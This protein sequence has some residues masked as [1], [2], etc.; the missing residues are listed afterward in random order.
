MFKVLKDWYAGVQWY[1][2]VYVDGWLYYIPGWV[3]ERDVP[4]V[5]NDWFKFGTCRNPY[6]R[7]VSI[8]WVTTHNKRLLTGKIRLPG[9]ETMP[10]RAFA[11]WLST[12]PVVDGVTMLMPQHQWYNGVG[13]QQYVHVENMA[14]ECQ[15]LPFWQKPKHIERSSNRTDL[16]HKPWREYYTGDAQRYIEQWAGDDFE[17]FGYDRDI[18]ERGT[19]ICDQVE[20]GGETR[21]GP[22]CTSP[23]DSPYADK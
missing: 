9:F 16:K 4:D 13:A 11:R 22:S 1:N 2:P 21:E 20:S 14:E 7:A 5:C 18:N 6:T 17:M 8:W 12:H 23:E 19:Y 3:H 15:T 10:F